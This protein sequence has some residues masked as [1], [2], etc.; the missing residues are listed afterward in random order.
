MDYEVGQIVLFPYTLFPDN[1][2][3][4]W[5]LCNG[6]QLSIQEYKA[7]FS[8]IGNKFGGDGVTTFA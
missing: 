2:P 6:Q 1:F 8:V 3:Y 5:L 7:V 4:N